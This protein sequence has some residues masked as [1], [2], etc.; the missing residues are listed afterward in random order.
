MKLYL[1]IHEQVEDEKE[2]NKSQLCRLY[3]LS[4]LQDIILVFNCRH[5]RCL[6]ANYFEIGLVFSTIV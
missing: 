6:K 5:H 3:H 4:P 2:L 1:S